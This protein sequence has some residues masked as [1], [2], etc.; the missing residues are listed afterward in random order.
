MSYTRGLIH[1]IYPKIREVRT[2]K[3]MLERHGSFWTPILSSFRL[4][5]DG[6]SW[7]VD[8]RVGN[9]KKI[10][11]LPNGPRHGN[12]SARS[13]TR[14]S[15]IRTDSDSNTIYI[16]SIYTC[17]FIHDSCMTIYSNNYCKI[18]DICPTYWL[19]K[20]ANFGLRSWDVMRGSVLCTGAYD[21]VTIK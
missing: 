18:W 2:P 12:S 14:W 8:V 10:C 16:V 5:R 6:Q 3:S 13:K 9:Q 7:L 20:I 17:I 11:P 19:E 1:L 15:K 4:A 21:T